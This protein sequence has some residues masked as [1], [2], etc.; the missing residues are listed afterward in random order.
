MT[1]EDQLRLA[2]LENQV[3]YLLR[4]LGISPEQAAGQAVS[5][6]G[7][8]AD[9]F[10]APA[11]PGAPPVG[12]P[13]MSS[14]PGD[15]ASYPEV[16]NAIQRGKVIEAIKIYRELTGLGLREAKQACD[17]AARTLR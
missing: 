3:G 13:M 2:R 15:P 5:T 16:V 9:V 4:H 17:A 11:V 1:P 6:F 10:G 14:G 7:S 8:P 12:G